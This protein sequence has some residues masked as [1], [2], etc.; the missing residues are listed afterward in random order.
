M[1][2]WITIIVTISL[3]LSCTIFQT[4]RGYPKKR[5]HYFIAYNFAKCERF[6]VFHC[7]KEDEI[8]KKTCI[9]ISTTP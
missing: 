2:E 9:K 6:S 3:G 4:Y 5:G 1:N 8:S 7:S